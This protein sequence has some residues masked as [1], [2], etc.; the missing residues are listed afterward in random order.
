MCLTWRRRWLRHRSSSAET[1]I[2]QSPVGAAP[3]QHNGRL[4]SS[5]FPKEASYS[6]AEVSRR[7]P[8]YCLR[9][10][11]KATIV[12]CGIL[13]NDSDQLSLMLPKMVKSGTRAT[14]LL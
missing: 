3:L 7:H 14:V 13:R 12:F 1:E 9:F 8:H 5:L 11:S 4:T 6:V 10:Y 2:L